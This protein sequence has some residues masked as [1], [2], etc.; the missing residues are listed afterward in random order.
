M[1]LP[2]DQISKPMTGE[3][4]VFVVSVTN[5]TEPETAASE[6]EAIRS[7]LKYYPGIEKQL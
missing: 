1:Y 6:T 7:R 3:S 4:G 5:R 2:V